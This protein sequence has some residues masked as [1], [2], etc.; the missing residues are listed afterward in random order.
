[1][2]KRVQGGI[3]TTEAIVSAYISGN[4]DVF[5]KILELHVPIGSL[6]ADVTYGTG[7]F[8]KNVDITKY[9]L[10]ASDISELKISHSPH[11]KVSSGVD[12]RKLPYKS[13]S[14]DCVV[15][16][17][18]YLESF[19][20]TKDSHKGGQGSHRAFGQYYSNGNEST[21]PG[22]GKW[23]QSVIDMYILSGKEA[24]RVLKNNGVFIVKCQDEVSA[25]KQRLTHVEIIS[26]FEQIG[27][28]VKDLFV[29]VRSNAPVVSRLLKQVHARKNHS[30][31]L[32]FEKTISVSKQ[33]VKNSIVEI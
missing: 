27:F 25:N 7:V 22:G 30:Y 31:F 16:D 1:M 10:R 3:S 8:W 33:K 20:R 15:L 24:F 4:A 11:L 23:H 32:V 9:T 12:C 17:P 14:I 26:G 5:P 6:I 21:A 19:Y 2:A 13:D 18:P 28:Y 29:V